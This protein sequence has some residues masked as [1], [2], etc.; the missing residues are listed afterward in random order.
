[1]FIYKGINKLVNRSIGGK[2]KSS[3]YRRQGRNQ[4]Q[5]SSG[6][7]ANTFSNTATPVILLESEYSKTSI[8]LFHHPE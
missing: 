2:S 1:M 5:K 4:K 6:R 7:S 8:R 3:Q